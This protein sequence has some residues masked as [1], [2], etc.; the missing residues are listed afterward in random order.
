MGTSEEL[1][2]VRRL[3]VRLS[4]ETLDQ[5]ASSFKANLSPRGVFLKV[6]KE[7]KP[8][9]KVSVEILLANRTR[10]LGGEGSVT[11]VGEPSAQ[12]L[13]GVSCEVRWDEESQPRVDE[14]LSRSTIPPPPGQ[15]PRTP[16][17]QLV[18][19]DSLPAPAPVPSGPFGTEDVTETESV[20]NMEV[21]T[22]SIDLAPT[23]EQAVT[24][25]EG[26]ESPLAPGFVSTPGGSSL[27][28][29]TDPEAPHQEED[30]TMESSAPD[31]A[32]WVA[33]D[34]SQ[35]ADADGAPVSDLEIQQKSGVWRWIKKRFGSN[36]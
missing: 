27:A 23:H 30:L 28:E 14:I 32:K 8:K 4:A 16:A 35:L 26:A 21:A 1:V 9:D 29:T 22:P 20:P 18:T 34:G 25:E 11:W 5:V 12:G 17:D 33:P 19:V 6:P 31:F 10:F 24:L 36:A 7:L 2:K 15:S 13:R 3:R